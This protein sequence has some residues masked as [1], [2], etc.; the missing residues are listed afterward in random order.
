MVIGII[1]PMVS[2]RVED[3]DLDLLLSA[4]DALQPQVRA[5]VKPQHLPDWCD[6]VAES[7][8]LP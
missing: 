5:L 8:S 7:K 2:K 4:V 1:K 3:T 6:G